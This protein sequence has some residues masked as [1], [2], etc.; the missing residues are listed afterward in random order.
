MSISSSICADCAN[1]KKEVW[2][3]KFRS[4]YRNVYK[5]SVTV[6]EFMKL[7]KEIEDFEFVE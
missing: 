2:T 4:I 6:K 3:K 7:V 5:E 1:K